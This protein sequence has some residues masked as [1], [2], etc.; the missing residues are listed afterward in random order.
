VSE[1]TIADFS[2]YPAGRTDNDGPFN[3]TKYRTEYLVPALQA[4]IVAHDKLRVRLDGVRSFGS[5]FLDEAFAGLVRYEGFSV[6][7][8]AGI[9]E[10]EAVAPVY[11][12]YKRLIG[13]Y[14]V[15]ATVDGTRRRA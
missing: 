9:L 2:R 11:Q 12:H 1:L 6:E 13:T 4:A 15:E 14:L 3:G 8:L 10:I 5:S 7:Q